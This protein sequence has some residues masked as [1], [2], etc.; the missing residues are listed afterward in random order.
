MESFFT[1]ID[2]IHNNYRKKYL[3]PDGNK[4]F[5]SYIP[6][7]IAAAGKSFRYLIWKKEK[8][9]LLLLCGKQRL[10]LSDAHIIDAILQ[11]SEDTIAWFLCQFIALY[12]NK[13]WQTILTIDT[14]SFVFDGI[15]PYPK[16]KKLCL[17]TDSL[18]DIDYFVFL[19][20]FIFYKDRCWEESG[21]IEGFGKTT[22]C[23]F[24]AL[25]DYYHNNSE[26]SKRFLKEI[27][28]TGMSFLNITELNNNKNRKLF[29][30]IESVKK[31]DISNYV[32]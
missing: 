23:K 11:M 26:T 5:S 20:S 15:A 10:Y 16:Q 27:G 1:L 25:I 18:I 14:I 6:I 4:D 30:N 13:G 8:A 19:L 17:F 2:T 22:L 12:Q 3:I 31:F 28:F 32:V 29:K 21:N 24:I 9:K 7:E